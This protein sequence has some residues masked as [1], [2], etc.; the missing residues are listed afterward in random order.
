MC[1][2]W[3]KTCHQ[4]SRVSTRLGH[5]VLCFFLLLPLATN[6][7]NA[8]CQPLR[9]S[10]HRLSKGV[11]FEI[12]LAAG[13]RNQ[14]WGGGGGAKKESP[15]NFHGKCCKETS[16][17]ASFSCGLQLLFFVTQSCI[18]CTQWQQI[19]GA[20][21]WLFE[22]LGPKLVGP[23]AEPLKEAQPTFRGTNTQT[24]PLWVFANIK[25]F[26]KNLHKVQL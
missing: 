9:R 19:I 15:Q 18:L 26:L 3:W 11:W 4:M 17:G 22:F 8:T 7:R 24:Q 5:R 1:A 14:G 20:L 2:A 6:E 25:A 21:N 23:S 13:L 10:G 16:S 12:C